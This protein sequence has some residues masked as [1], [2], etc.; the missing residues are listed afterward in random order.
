MA[1]FK[2]I[3]SAH[4]VVAGRK[5]LCHHD[6]KHPIKKGDRCLEVPVGLGW[7]GYCTGCGITMVEKGMAQLKDLRGQL[8]RP[9]EV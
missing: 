1:K 6:K 4:V 3:I 9:P 2:S 5:R 8:G 7:K